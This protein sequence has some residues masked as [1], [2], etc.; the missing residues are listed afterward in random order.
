MPKKSNYDAAQI[1]VLK[2]LEA[3]RKRP[4]MYIGDTSDGSGLH[5]MIFEVVDNSVDEALAGYCSNIWVT[6]HKDNSVSVAD[7][8]R[9]IPVDIHP[10]EKRPTCEVVMTELHAGGKFENSAYKVSGGLHGVGVSVV[11]ALS[12][13]LELTVWRD[14]QIHS[15]GFAR[16]ALTSPIEVTGK[17][18]ETGTQVTFLADKEV[19]GKIAYDWATL[20]WRFRELAFLNTGLS[21]HFEDERS[22]KS[23]VLSYEGGVMSYAEYLAKSKSADPVHKNIIH[24]TGEGNEGST[25]EASLQWNDGYRESVACYTNNIPQRDGGSHLTGMRSALT[26]TIKSYIDSSD[27]AKKNKVTISAEDVREGLVCVLSLRTPDP[28]FS[29]QTKDK[30]VSSEVRPIVEEAISES[31]STFLENYPKDAK[32][33]FNKI[34]SAAQAREAARQA[35]DLTRRKSAFESGGLPGKLADCQERDPYKSELYIVEG[36]SAGGSAKQGRNR[37]NQAILPLRGKVLNVEKC[38]KQQV[39]SSKEIVNLCTALGG[40]N[41]AGDDV[42]INKVRYRRVIIMT[43]AD[44]DGAHISTL[45]LTFFFR[46]MLSLLTN[47]C[48]YLACPPLYKVVFRRQEKFLSDD[49]ELETY[50]RNITLEGVKY[51]VAKKKVTEANLTEYYQSWIKAKALIGTL[52]KQ[53]DEKLLTALMTIPDVLNLST[54]KSAES[55]ASEITKAMKKIY[56]EVD[57][58]ITVEEV[59]EGY[60][61]FCQRTGLGQFSSFLVDQTFCDSPEYEKLNILSERLY[62]VLLEP[63]TVSR[64]GERKV[65]EFTASSFIE[66]IDWLEDLARKECVIQRFKGLGEMNAGQLWD[67]TLDPENRRLIRVRVE[68]AEEADR[69]F[70]ML[71]GNVVAPR[72]QFIVNNGIEA[73]LDI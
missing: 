40:M 10:T 26:R 33:I 60:Q 23:E 54:E 41:T 18:R 59:D 63:C 22:G 71:M 46:N 37:S 3:V 31:L 51:Q 58:N 68:D 29:S 61:L 1:K 39:F 27:V 47:G 57:V 12:E 64:P 4:G 44:V 21:I 42:D 69:V 50:M 15:L 53:Y 25:I 52:S 13:S 28:K 7:D 19:F 45:L 38:N 24:C 73:S 30:L 36:D 72:K 20:A 9:G 55:G 43:D 67:T 65:V 16:G 14:K 70:S 11:N 49:R 17:T 8:G 35:R 62:D 48:V 34:V 32:A 2:G 5:H 56:G 66:A 6:L